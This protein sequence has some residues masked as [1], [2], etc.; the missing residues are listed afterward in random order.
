MTEHQDRL[1][2]QAQEIVATIPGVTI[3]YI[4]NLEFGRDDRGIFSF[5]IRAASGKRRIASA[6]IRPKIAGSW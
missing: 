3:G 5:L 1:Y 6:G 4:G 2:E